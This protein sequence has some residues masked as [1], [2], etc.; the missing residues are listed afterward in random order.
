MEREELHSVEQ[1]KVRRAQSKRERLMSS[2]GTKVA[3]L[4]QT[5]PWNRRG[6]MRALKT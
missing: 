6:Y 3:A 4:L 1:V 5:W 2:W